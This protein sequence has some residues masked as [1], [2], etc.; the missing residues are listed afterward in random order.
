MA[1]GRRGRVAAERDPSEIA[2]DDMLAMPQ[3]LP[4]VSPLLP[5]PLVPV[6]IE[7]RRLFHPLDEFAP[8]RD[9]TGQD[10][11]VRIKKGVVRRG[12][13]GMP[14]RAPRSLSGDLEKNLG[15]RM[16]HTVLICARRRIRREVLF[17]IKKTRK[18]S[19]ARRHRRNYFT[20]IHC[21]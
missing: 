19:G 15:F 9:L 6:E 8:A 20:D 4:V 3:P 11:E 16:P 12:P 17:A 5:L 21:R 13:K 7:D 10:A 14:L 2:I 1:R 18:G